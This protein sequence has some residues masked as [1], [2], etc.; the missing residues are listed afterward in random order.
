MSA[1]ILERAS[2]E[3]TSMVTVT[4]RTFLPIRITAAG[5]SIP[6]RHPWGATTGYALQSDRQE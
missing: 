1:K 5:A 6:V 3:A 4:V 2:A